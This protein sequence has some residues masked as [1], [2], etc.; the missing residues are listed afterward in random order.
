MQNQNAV[1]SY[2]TMNGLRDKIEILNRKNIELTEGFKQSKLSQ[3]MSWKLK[4]PKI[5]MQ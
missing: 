5:L 2:N 4:N 3:K 1:K